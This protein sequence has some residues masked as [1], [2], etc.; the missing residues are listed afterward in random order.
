MLRMP[1]DSFIFYVVT[2][3]VQIVGVI[4]YGLLWYLRDKQNEK[5]LDG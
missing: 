5:R 4:V 2:Q 3:V 1:T